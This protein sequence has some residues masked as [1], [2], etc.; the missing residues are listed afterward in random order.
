MQ[1]KHM[2]CVT[3]EEGQFKARSENLDLEVKG[4]STSDVL[5]LLAKKIEGL[6]FWGSK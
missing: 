3:I 1:Y 2:I 6:L 4:D 5:R